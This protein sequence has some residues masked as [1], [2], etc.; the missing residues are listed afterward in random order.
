MDTPNSPNGVGLVDCLLAL[1]ISIATDGVGAY[2]AI[3]Y[4]WAD[5]HIGIFSR[6]LHAVG[7]DIKP[8]PRLTSR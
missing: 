6:S 2:R 8:T 3:Y 1:L 5:S 7:A 4:L